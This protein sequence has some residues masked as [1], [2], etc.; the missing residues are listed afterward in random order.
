M[1]SMLRFKDP[2]EFKKFLRSTGLREAAPITGKKA[3]APAPLS[4]V[5][6]RDTTPPP[7]P[8]DSPLVATAPKGSEIERRFAQ[9]I[10][11][12][13]L[14]DPEREYFHIAGRD[15]RLDFAWPGRKLGV[16]VQGMAHRIKAKFNTD[17]E[18]R[19]LAM[20]AGWRILEV[21]GDAVRNET[22][23]AWLMKLWGMAP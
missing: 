4:R 16:E 3:V 10:R 6:G 5:G 7:A 12:A 17:I 22:G 1:S 18:K 15:F 19:A 11:A 14:P 23:I 20:L 8:A 9:Q 13:G 21:N 2:E